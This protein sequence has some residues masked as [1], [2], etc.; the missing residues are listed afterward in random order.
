[1]ERTVSPQLED[2][3]QCL[4]EL[5]FE[6]KED[7]LDSIRT[8][9]IHQESKRGSKE[10]VLHKTGSAGTGDEGGDSAM[11]NNQHNSRE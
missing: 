4:V 3:K 2:T 1:L 8:A 6:N 9:K 10:M 7:F 5:Q 11:S